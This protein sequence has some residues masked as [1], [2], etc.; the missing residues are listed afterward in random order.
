MLWSGSTV[1]VRHPGTDPST[2]DEAPP[3]SPPPPATALKVAVVAER[4]QR[5]PDGR[6]D[7]ATGQPRG[8]ERGGHGLEQHRADLDRSAR[9]GV[10]GGKLGVVAESRAGHIEIGDG[11]LDDRSRRIEFGDVSD[12][13]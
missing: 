2:R 13:D 12:R 7:V 5:L 6:V 10:D 8:P 3:R 1:T 4:D 9:G 11:S